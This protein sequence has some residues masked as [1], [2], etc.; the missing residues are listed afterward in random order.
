LWENRLYQSACELE[1]KDVRWRRRSAW[2]H[3]VVLSNE[4]SR[5]K[6][7]RMNFI[8]PCLPGLEED[9]ISFATKGLMYT[10]CKLNGSE[11]AFGREGPG[12]DFPLRQIAFE[13]VNMRLVPSG[14]TAESD[15]HV[16]QCTVA[17]SKEV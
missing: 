11:S 6:K 9:R 10:L 3:H 2:L 14:V 13:G 4:I 5:E 7:K 16:Q 1:D 8:L 17:K 15:C 12:F